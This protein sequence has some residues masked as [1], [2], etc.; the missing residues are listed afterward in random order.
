MHLLELCHPLERVRELLLDLRLLCLL[1]LVLLGLLFLSVL[2]L[3]NSA[4]MRH[5]DRKLQVFGFRSQHLQPACSLHHRER[6]RGSILLATL[7]LGSFLWLRGLVG[8]RTFVP[9]VDLDSEAGV[10]VPLHGLHPDVAHR[11]RG[12]AVAEGDVLH[13]L[14]VAHAIQSQGIL[15]AM[16]DDRSPN[17]AIDTPS[18]RE[19]RDPLIFDR[20]QAP[21]VAFLLQC[22]E[23]DQLQHAVALRGVFPSQDLRRRKRQ[24][25]IFL[26]LDAHGLQC[27]RE[28]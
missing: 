28:L 10:L 16:L 3:L 8:V 13:S 6:C 14:S 20:H 17:L 12:H 2:P 24:G 7:G 4:S 15:A 22:E 21:H 9:T 23:A 25:Q 18:H 1:L 5:L 11:D 27:E 19:L 26:L